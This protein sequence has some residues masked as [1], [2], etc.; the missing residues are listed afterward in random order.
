MQI[1]TLNKG[2]RSAQA[3]ARIAPQG[4]PAAVPAATSDTA[5]P[6]S[7]PVCATAAVAF[8]V[9]SLAAN[10]VFSAAAFPTSWM[11]LTVFWAAS[12]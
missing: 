12:T 6:P 5:F 10:V 8:A 7:R 9:A 2:L 4:P 3:A 11:A 1:N